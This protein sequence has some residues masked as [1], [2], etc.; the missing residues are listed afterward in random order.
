MAD[1][2]N[3]GPEEAIL[4][5]DTGSD[6]T[7]FTKAI[8][9]SV[10]S[11]L[12]SRLPRAGITGAEVDREVVEAWLTRSTTGPFNEEFAGYIRSLTHVGGGTT[13]PGMRVAL[14]PQMLIGIF[15]W[16]EGEILAY[17]G[18]VSDTV[19]L[20]G[21]GGIWMDELM[22]QLGI[23]LEPVLG[24]PA[25]PGTT[26]GATRPNS[27]RSRTWPASA[28]RKAGSWVRRGPCSARRPVG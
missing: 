17:L 3:F 28:V 15:A 25:D 9:A 4:L 7:L 26:P 12:N 10:C 14:A 27:I 24:S 2:A 21:V 6:L 23:M 19:T 1:F 5:S 18:D 8:A 22:L 13:F 11:Y 16:L 20:S